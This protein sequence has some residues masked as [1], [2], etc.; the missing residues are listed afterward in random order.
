[1]ISGKLGIHD[2]YFRFFGVSFLGVNNNNGGSLS[3][4]KMFVTVAIK[5]HFL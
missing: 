1:M 3:K 2:L 5:Y 4:K